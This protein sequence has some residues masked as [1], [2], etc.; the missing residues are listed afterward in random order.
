MELNTIVTCLFCTERG[1]REIRLHL[2]DLIDAHLFG[3]LSGIPCGNSGRADRRTAFRIGLDPR[4]IQL[5]EDGCPVVMTSRCD[6]PVSFDLR[7]FP[8]TE[9]RFAEPSVRRDSGCFHAD[10][11]AAALCAF[12]VMSDVLLRDPAVG[13]GIIEFYRRCH[14]QT[15][16]YFG[17]VD[18]DRITCFH[19]FSL[20]ALRVGFVYGKYSTNPRILR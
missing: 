15:V 9:V 2:M 16:L 19:V 6:R 7:V 8:Q 4:M 5:D 11:S 17:F 13:T 20:S 1:V 14:R 18:D 10:Q 3:K 12:P